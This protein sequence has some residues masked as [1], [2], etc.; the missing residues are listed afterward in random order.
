MGESGLEIRH[1]IAGFLGHQR[2][3]RQVTVLDVV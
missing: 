3:R 1:Q 2:L